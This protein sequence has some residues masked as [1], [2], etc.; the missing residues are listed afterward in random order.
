MSQ[1]AEVRV[2]CECVSCLCHVAR[3]SQLGEEVEGRPRESHLGTGTT[4]TAVAATIKISMEIFT[5]GAS[6]KGSL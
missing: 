3:G 2:Y 6:P 1:R 4:T 5:M